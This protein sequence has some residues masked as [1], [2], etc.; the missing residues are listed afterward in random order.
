MRRVCFYMPPLKKASGGMRVIADLAAHL[1]QEGREALLAGSA[2][3]PGG[4]E[5][6]GGAPFI[7]LA[8]LSLR[9]G[10]YWIVPE[11]WPNALAPG[12][13]SGAENVV[14]AQNWAYVHGNLPEGSFWDQLPVKFWAVSEPVAQFVKATTGRE[15]PVLRP[16]INPGLFYPPKRNLSSPLKEGERPVIAWMPRKNPALA[17]QIRNILEARLRLSG[18]APPAWL[19]I[20]G[21]SLEEVAALMRQAHIF[22]ATGFPEGCPLPPLEAMASG[23]IVCGFAGFGGWDYMRP[24]PPGLYLSGESQGGGRNGFYAAD[25][26]TLA[27]A[28]GLERAMRL[29]SEGG[30]VLEA[31]RKESLKTAAEY[32]PQKQKESLLAL[33]K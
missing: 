13:K 24:A 33:F 21:K 29:L 11:G 16:A 20:S 3:L 10:D 7:S 9:P 26:D 22:L 18:T 12:L 28:L 2:P 23:L 25:A 14:Y 4:L 31:L 6:P 30:P 32:S 27:A 5:R 19:E 17:R 8:E 15:A 1:A